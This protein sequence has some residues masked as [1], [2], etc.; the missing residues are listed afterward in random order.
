MAKKE[1]LDV[2]LVEQGFFATREKAKKA[3][4]A[5]LVSVDGVVHTKAGDQ[6]AADLSPDAVTIKGDPV[7]F[8]SR[9]GLKLKKGLE[10]FDLPVEGLSFIDI[11]ASTGG[12]TDCLLQNGAAKVYAV[13]VGY[14]QLDYG[15]RRDPRVVVLER[16]N[17]RAIDPALIPET[18]DGTVM[19]VSFISITKLLPAIIQ[20]IEP[21]ALG[22]WLIKPQFEAGRGAVG[23]KGVVRDPAI[24][25]QVLSEVTAA[26]RAN[27]FD[28]I[29]LDISPIKGPAGNIEFLCHTRYAGRDQEGSFSARSIY[30]LVDEA[31][32][33]KEE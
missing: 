26:I 23:K 10:V 16:T 17:F 6:I 22:I 5:G 12:F 2:F 33:P 29:G 7:P 28:V 1:R 13:D 31:H 14:G 20:F 27:G 19:D 15:L 18:V 32:H 25:R 3:V 21:G 4:M 24:H 11:G 9:G 30:D 8:V